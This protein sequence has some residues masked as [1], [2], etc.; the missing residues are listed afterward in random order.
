MSGAPLIPPP[1]PDIYDLAKTST[2][3]DARAGLRIEL[4]RLRAHA[5]AELPR[6]AARAERLA[7]PQ[8]GPLTM[9]PLLRTLLRYVLL[10]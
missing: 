9:V 4:A 3:L 7:R 10:V 5:A 8:R 1:L 2:W 6:I